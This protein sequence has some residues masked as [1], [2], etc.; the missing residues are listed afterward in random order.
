MVSNFY[1]TDFGILKV[2][3]SSESPKPLFFWC[4]QG[5]PSLFHAS[6][7]IFWVLSW[8]F[9]LLS[10]RFCY[11]L[12]LR[13]ALSLA[14]TFYLTVS[15]SFKSCI[16]FRFFGSFVIS[17][18]TF[19]FIWFIYQFE[20]AFLSLSFWFAKLNKLSVFFIKIASLY[21]RFW[22]LFDSILNFSMSL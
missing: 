5:F 22:I 10:C 16:L 19:A 3:P 12:L 15:Y 17:I 11:C 1:F 20:W 14:L 18:R 21:G 8:L 9:C 4:V 6:F 2:V 7:V 13:L